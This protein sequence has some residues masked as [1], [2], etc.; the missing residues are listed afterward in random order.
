[1]ANDPYSSGV[2]T[3][4]LEGISALGEMLKTVSA[5]GE[6]AT[7]ATKDLAAKIKIMSM[8]SKS[9][10]SDL[11]ILIKT[12]QTLKEKGEDA[13]DSIIVLTDKIA[14]NAGI[15]TEATRAELSDRLTQY[16]ASAEG[17]VGTDKE[18]TLRRAML[19]KETKDTNISIFKDEMLQK[20]AMGN[21]L[22]GTGGINTAQGIWKSVG[23]QMQ[24]AGSGAAE[25]AGGF[26]G[27]D[28]AAMASIA[29]IAGGFLALGIALNAI[30]ESGAKG[31]ASLAKTHRDLG[32]ATAQAFAEGADFNKRLSETSYA[33]YVSSSD[34]EKFV[35]VANSQFR[36]TFAALDKSAD[37][38][39]QTMLEFV[40]DMG[41]LGARFGLS[42]EESVKLSS[43][44]AQFSR[45]SK[46]VAEKSF[47]QLNMEAISLGTSVETLMGP[48]Q[49]LAEVAAYSGHTVDYSVGELGVFADAVQNISKGNNINGFK[50]MTS[51]MQASFVSKAVEFAS[52]MDELRVAA[53][54]S[55]SHPGE[56]FNDMLSRVAGM[57]GTQKMSESVGALE[58]NQGFKWDQANSATSAFAL[59][60]MMG[61]QG[62]AQELMRM[63]TFMHRG[64]MSGTLSEESIKAYQAQQIDKNLEAGKTTGQYLAQGGDPMAA[65]INIAKDIVKIITAMA[66][67]TIFGGG[68]G[69]TGSVAKEVEARMTGA[70]PK[71]SPSTYGVHQTGLNRARIS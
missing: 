9:S 15:M 45:S 28:A 53:I 10:A 47:Y 42:G 67:S 13:R 19:L 56:S 16:K 35:D 65:L 40:S 39:S 7:R 5:G 11:G 70:V 52:K 48:F 33:L 8:A 37:N 21:A 57:G 4:G 34:M 38:S 12:F 41:L 43:R 14:E 22:I 46:D 25:L 44:M 68:I 29:T 69:H 62:T 66:S 50:N 60:K 71:S 6:N 1:M 58:K 27:V 59:A 61:M 20:K 17:L 3:S 36:M 31:A 63:G 55:G 51:Q 54:T 64:V 32:D 24:L 49:A 26:L 30:I 18:T 2:G 23:A